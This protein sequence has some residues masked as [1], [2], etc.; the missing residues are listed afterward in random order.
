[1]ARTGQLPGRAVW[2][3]RALRRELERLEAARLGIY[4]HGTPP[5][6]RLIDRQGG[7]RASAQAE[8]AF[9]ALRALPDGSGPDAALDALASADELPRARHLAVKA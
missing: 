7:R 3:R 2:L 4:V 5:T 9:D 8:L 6:V 1:M